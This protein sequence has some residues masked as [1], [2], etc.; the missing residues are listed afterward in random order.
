MR[1]DIFELIYLVSYMHALSRET[2][3]MFFMLLF[4]QSE[5]IERIGWDDGGESSFSDIHKRIGGIYLCGL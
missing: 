2:K 5:D 3:C 4:P 1:V